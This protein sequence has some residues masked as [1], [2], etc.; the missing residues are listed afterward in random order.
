MT[1][2]ICKKCGHRY[3]AITSPD[4]PEECVECDGTEFDPFPP[5]E[6]PRT[7]DSA[8]KKLRSRSKGK[9]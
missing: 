1:G 6:T 5:V 2:W 9:R 8:K 3:V 4:K 7:R